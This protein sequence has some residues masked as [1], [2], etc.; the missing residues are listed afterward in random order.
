LP[1]GFL[2]CERDYN[3]S[4]DGLPPPWR[5]EEEVEVLMVAE[6]LDSSM[7][8][9]LVQVILVGRVEDHRLALSADKMED[10]SLVLLADK[11]E[12]SH[13][14]TSGAKAEDHKEITGRLQMVEASMAIEVGFKGKM[15]DKVFKVTMVSLV[16]MEIFRDMGMNFKEDRQAVLILSLALE[17]ENIGVEIM[18]IMDIDVPMIRETKLAYIEVVPMLGGMEEEAVGAIW[19]LGATIS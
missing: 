2:L 5:D 17:V 15:E 14:L 18:E 3:I 11:V 10:H 19:L 12:D 16:S 13:R 9:P 4:T 6:V 7:I 1:L 8:K